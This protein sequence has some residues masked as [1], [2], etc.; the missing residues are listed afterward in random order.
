MRNTT[1]Q[2]QANSLPPHGHRCEAPST[3]PR[4][5]VTTE[6]RRFRCPSRGRHGQRPRARPSPCPLSAHATSKATCSSSV[7]DHP[8]GG[9]R[10]LA[11]RRRRILP[12]SSSTR[13][14]PIHDSPPCAA[15]PAHASHAYARRAHARL[16]RCLSLHVTPLTGTDARPACLAPH[17][18]GSR[19]A[20]FQ[21]NA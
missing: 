10:H 5:L 21:S 1:T 16:A 13:E 14:R 9:D 7:V 8:R 6:P 19:K 15:K 18:H 17:S 3:A 12:T 20:S 2:R 11:R 4:R